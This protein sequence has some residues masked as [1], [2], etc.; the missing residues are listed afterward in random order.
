MQKGGAQ[1]GGTQY[2]VA[3]GG[4]CS[5]ESGQQDCS[6]AILP[7]TR[8][9]KE[10]PCYKPGTCLPCIESLQARGC[11]WSL[12]SPPS[13]PPA[14]GE[15]SCCRRGQPPEPGLFSGQ[16]A[17]GGWGEPPDSGST[18]RQTACC[19]VG[20]TGGES[21]PQSLGFH[22]VYWLLGGR[23]AASQGQPPQP[24]LCSRQPALCA[25]SKIFFL[26]YS[27]CSRMGFN[28]CDNKSLLHHFQ[29]TLYTHRLYSRDGINTAETFF[30]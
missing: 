26:I 23:S 15:G 14:S 29:K 16:A 18:P 22:T 27:C 3:T 17:V 5:I 2:S 9:G 12:V 6:S 24:S 21:S 13:R 19:G 1:R 28:L 7:A 8:P 11:C 4:S 25:Q 20:A 30:S 10:A